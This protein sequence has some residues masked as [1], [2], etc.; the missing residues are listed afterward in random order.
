MS[1]IYE[2][3]EIRIQRLERAQRRWRA[4]TSLLAATLIGITLI[5]ASGV[6]EHDSSNE[7][8]TSTDFDS[9][10]ARRVA[11]VD[12]DG[13]ERVV[14]ETDSGKGQIVVRSGNG[15]AVVEI[16]EDGM[17][18]SAGRLALYASGQPH[19]FAG[20]AERDSSPLVYVGAMATGDDATG[21]RDGGAISITNGDGD[22]VVDL[23]V[24]DDGAGRIG[25]SDPSGGKNRYISARD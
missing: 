19:H 4:I 23:V 7:H 22:P 15:R 17:A 14:L 16:G 2:K 20:R 10:R 18:C 1:A 6:Q 5:A 3:I 24:F 21:M 8:A 25:I 12:G 11:I 13:E 9:L